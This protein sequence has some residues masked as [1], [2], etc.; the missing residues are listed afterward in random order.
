MVSSVCTGC[1]STDTTAHIATKTDIT[2][3]L[4]ELG[5]WVLSVDSPWMS[6]DCQVMRVNHRC[7]FG[8][9]S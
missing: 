5:Q 7:G 3:D 9:H 4:E 6:G 8:G 1:D 2:E